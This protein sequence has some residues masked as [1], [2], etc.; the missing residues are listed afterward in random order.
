MGYL[1]E[2]LNDYLLNEHSGN[3]KLVVETLKDIYN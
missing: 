1:D 2:N 3:I